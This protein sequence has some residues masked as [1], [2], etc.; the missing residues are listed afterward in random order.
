MEQTD[1][2]FFLRMILPLLDRIRDRAAIRFLYRHTAAINIKKGKSLFQANS[3]AANGNIFIIQNGL[4][5]GYITNNVQERTDIWLG[6]KNS[7][8]IQDDTKAAQFGIFN[9]EAIEDALVFVIDLGE[10]EEGCAWYPVL[11]ALFNFYF[12]PNAMADVINRNIL[13]RLQDIDSRITQFRKMYPA[14]YTRLPKDLLLSYLDTGQRFWP[15]YNNLK[16]N[17]FDK[18]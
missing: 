1:I 6:S 4:V 17:V 3:L 2:K 13:F 8:Y 15:M 10:L 5:N 9:I 12:F 11:N 7:I 18:P 16:K 14:L